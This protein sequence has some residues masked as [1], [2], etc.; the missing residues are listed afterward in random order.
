MPQWQPP[1]AASKKARARR[2]AAPSWKLSRIAVCKGI[3][4]VSG[5]A[6]RGCKKQHQTAMQQSVRTKTSLFRHG[7]HPQRSSRVR[8]HASNTSLDFRNVGTSARLHD[9][10]C[11]SSTDGQ[12]KPLAL[13]PLVLHEAIRSSRVRCVKLIDQVT[14]GNDHCRQ[15]SESPPMRI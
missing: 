2:Q 7:L 13:I 3:E 15:M 12:A 5:L 4:A 9:S 10:T 11:G 6:R 1:T 8:I 14:I